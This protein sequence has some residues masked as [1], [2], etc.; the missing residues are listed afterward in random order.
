MQEAEISPYYGCVV[1]TDPIA[2]T[3]TALKN[4]LLKYQN[5]LESGSADLSSLDQMLTELDSAGL[6]EYL[7]YY[8]EQLDNWLAEQQ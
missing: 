7:D 4:V 8:Q 6:Q 1:N 5:T 3:I 2:N